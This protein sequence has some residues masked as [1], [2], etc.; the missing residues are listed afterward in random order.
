MNLAKKDS[1]SSDKNIKESR[2]EQK[3]LVSKENNIAKRLNNLNQTIETDSAKLLEKVESKD[4]NNKN[5]EFKTYS[6]WEE[7]MDDFNENF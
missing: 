1:Y 2:E 6:S 7:A 5:E 4:N 3:Q